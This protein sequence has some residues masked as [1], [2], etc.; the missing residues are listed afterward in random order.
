DLA[1]LQRL[2][3][4]DYSAH[5]ATDKRQDATRGLHLLVKKH[6][7]ALRSLSL[8]C[9]IS[10]FPLDGILAHA[11]T[12]RSLRFRDHVGFGEED[13]RCPTLWP[14]DLE[15]LGRQLPFVHTLEIDMD[16]ALCDPPEFLRAICAFKKLHTLTLHVQTVLHPLEIVHP[17]MDRDH[18]A[19]V[20]T[21]GYLIQCKQDFEARAVPGCDREAGRQRGSWRRPDVDCSPTQALTLRRPRLSTTATA[22]LRLNLP[23]CSV[24]NSFIRPECSAHLVFS[25]LEV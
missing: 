18:D 12:L 8:T 14:A 2:H 7:R 1:N 10:S 13:R 24:W 11:S 3:C 22:P 4:E 15:T 9:H 5:Q 21:F 19:A 16:I 6:I 20:R 23:T 25:S 17:G